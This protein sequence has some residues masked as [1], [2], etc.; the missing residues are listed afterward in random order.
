M[1]FAI[2]FGWAVLAPVGAISTLFWLVSVVRHH[3]PLN[4]WIVVVLLVVCGALSLLLIHNKW[5][6]TN[7][8][9]HHHHAGSTSHHYAA[10]VTIH[11]GA[12]APGA[13]AQE[14]VVAPA[15]SPHGGRPV[16]RLSDY[17]EYPEDGHR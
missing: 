11:M 10:P 6:G 14:V 4:F 9:T 13:P 15:V 1:R 5:A 7:G 12:P 17:V 16:V 3:H 2:R 8:A